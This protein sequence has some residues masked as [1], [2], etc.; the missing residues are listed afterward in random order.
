MLKMKRIEGGHQNVWGHDHKIIRAE[1]KHA[2]AD[3]H[4]SFEM[5]H[6]ATRT[7]RLICIAKATGS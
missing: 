1:W 4:T 6:M 5:R 2:L 7:D 3:D